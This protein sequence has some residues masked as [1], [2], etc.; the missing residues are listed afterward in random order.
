MIK[1]LPPRLAS[2]YT[3]TAER[4]PEHRFLI[5]RLIAKDKAFLE[6]CIECLEARTAL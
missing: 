2:T 5:R 6:L 4:L 3:A 1:G